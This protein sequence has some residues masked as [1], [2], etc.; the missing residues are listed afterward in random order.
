MNNF[1]R[2]ATA[3]LHQIQAVR[4]RLNHFLDIKLTSLTTTFRFE[5]EL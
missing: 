4:G 2:A 5:G 1:W 3:Y